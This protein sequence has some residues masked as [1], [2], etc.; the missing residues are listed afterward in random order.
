[1]LLSSPNRLSQTLSRGSFGVLERS[2]REQALVY[3]S[4]L[5]VSTW[6]ICAFVPLTKESRAAHL[7]SRGEAVDSPLDGG[8]AVSHK[9]LQM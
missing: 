4:T 2:R 5:Q 9:R 7:D 1:M 3:T 8:A 6:I